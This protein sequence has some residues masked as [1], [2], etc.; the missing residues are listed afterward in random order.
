MKRR[1]KELAVINS[2]TSAF[3]PES[4]QNGGIYE[5]ISISGLD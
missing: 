3:I 4:A 5:R 2:F 1:V